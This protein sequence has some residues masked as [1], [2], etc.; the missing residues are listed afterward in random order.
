M[1]AAPQTAVAATPTAASHH[2]CPSGRPPSQPHPQRLRRRLGVTAS[3]GRGSSPSASWRNHRPPGGGWRR[4][5][6]RGPGDQGRGCGASRG[7]RG[8][9]GL[10]ERSQAPGRPPRGGPTASR[11]PPPGAARWCSRGGAPRSGSGA[12]GA[13]GGREGLLC[14][15]ADVALT[16][17]A[18]SDVH[19]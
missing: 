1:Q 8:A 16:L 11:S 9:A 3:E 2:S 10:P 13:G 5:A 4:A 18:A 17:K 12:A 7:E 19:L 14:L 6:G 15:R